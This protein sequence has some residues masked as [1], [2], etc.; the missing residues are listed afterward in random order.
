MIESGLGRTFVNEQQKLA[1]T[2]I[3]GPLIASARSIPARTAQ[4]GHTPH[5]VR[6]EHKQLAA[7]GRCNEP[8]KRSATLHYRQAEAVVRSGAGPFTEQELR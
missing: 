6:N 5:L 3:E 8:F 4:M 2:S 7:G 1:R